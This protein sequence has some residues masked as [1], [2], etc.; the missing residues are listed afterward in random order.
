MRWPE[1]RSFAFTI[2]DDTDLS[3]LPD[4]KRVYDVIAECGFRTTKSVWPLRGEGP[5]KV[6]GSTCEDP[7]YLAWVHELKR[8]GFEIGF[9]NA[10]YHTSSREETI[11]GLDR[12][13]ELFGHDPRTMANHAGCREGIY[14]GSARVSGWRRLAYN[15][16]DRGRHRNMFQG[17]RPGTP[18]F[19]GDVCRRRITYVRN[20][21][22]GGLDTLETCPQLPYHD[23][24]R[25]YVD[26][27]FAST[28][29]ATGPSFIRAIRESEQDRLAE[30]GGACIMYTHLGAGF[31]E[32]GRVRP[33]FQRL[34][35]RLAGLGGWLVPVHVLLDY[36][37][38]E[39]GEHRLSP[40]ERARLER[41]W[42]AH[43]IRTRGTT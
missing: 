40:R 22:F 19:W 6:G 36:I 9:H 8:E 4:I 20:F 41:R 28:E 16:L 14:W 34:M 29:G 35:R 10:T 32:D 27:W 1:G 30:R 42:L 31:V 37:R 15:V 2:F 26:Q 7:A 5:P 24:D 23:P 25:P 11:R 17:H 3:R 43:R 12:F 18:W 13:R 39:R 21:V 33:E 38:R